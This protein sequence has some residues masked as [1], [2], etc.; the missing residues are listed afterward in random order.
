MSVTPTSHFQLLSYPFGS[1]G[2]DIF[3]VI[4]GFIISYS[5]GRYIGMTRAKEFLVHRFL[6]LNPVYYLATLL[7]L[8]SDLH[9][10]I[11]LHRTHITFPV[12]AK[13]ILLL[14]LFDGQYW[15]QAL[16]PPAWSLSF[17]WLFYLLFFLAIALQWKNKT[18]F[19]LIAG[20]ILITAGLLLNSRDTRI[21]FL[22]NPIMA[23][24]LLGSALCYCW[25]RWDLPVLASL[26]M[27]AAGIGLCIGEWVMIHNLGQIG[28]MS[29]LVG[30]ASSIERTLCWGPPA[31]LLVAGCVF[32]E[33]KGW[34]IK[35]WNNKTIGLLGDSSY[36]IYLV[37][38]SVIG[39]CLSIRNHVHI[40]TL[41]DIDVLLWVLLAVGGGIFFH[42]LI[43]RPWLQRIRRRSRPPA[44]PK[45]SASY[46]SSASRSI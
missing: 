4:S 35:L 27:L 11:Q 7:L 23:E 18:S 17:E 40:D 24:F 3:F 8:L 13:S 20:S 28:E 9:K 2:V 45:D 30:G 34:A 15:V 31:F 33:K 12:V 1:F 19:L 14:P 29:R 32:L 6:R 38:L 26:V 5:A 42:L 21:H 37:H 43:E 16:L 10:L 39:I 41:P 25:S 22:S 36:S 46:A 44:S